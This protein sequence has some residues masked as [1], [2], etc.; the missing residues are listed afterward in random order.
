MS[1]LVN[2]CNID[3]VF[4]NRTINLIRGDITDTK[5][6]LIVFSTYSKVGSPIEGDVYQ[7][8]KR[9]YKVQLS[10]KGN[11]T[12][13]IGDVKTQYWREKFE[14]VSQGFLMARMPIYKDTEE[15][16]SN[17]DKNIRAIFSSIKA[18]EFNDIYFN[19]ISFPIIEGGKDLD[20]YES[21]KILLKYSLKYLKESRNTETINFYILEEEEE[22]KWNDAFEKNLGRTYY[23]Q[24]SLAVIE[25]LIVGLKEFIEIVIKDGGYKELEYVLKL[26][27]RELERVDSLSI[28]SI[29]INSRKI[30]EIIAKDIASR[31]EININKIKYDLSSIL[32]LLASKDILAPWVTQYLHTARVFGNK[33]AHVETAIKYQPSKLYN[34]DFISILAALYNILNFWYYNKE[35]I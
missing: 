7:A 26:I 4:G 23:K 21:I 31:K 18:L 1:K 15:L 24:G 10:G 25:S 6:E 27:Y 22:I 17:Y 29:A 35:K 14:Q 3:T 33:S 30:C 9:L 32:N 34:S 5:V 19:D 12:T 13:E 2:T 28:N 16:I 11:V 20:Y 8:L